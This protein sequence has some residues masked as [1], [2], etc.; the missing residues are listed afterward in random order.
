VKPVACDCNQGELHTITRIL[1]ALLVF[2]ILQTAM[3]YVLLVIS[4]RQ[5]M[6]LETLLRQSG[7]R[8]N[9]SVLINPDT[10]SQAV[11]IRDGSGK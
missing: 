9:T 8:Q 1:T 11:R 10:L 3:F 6:M 4:K 7:E 2:L 5:E